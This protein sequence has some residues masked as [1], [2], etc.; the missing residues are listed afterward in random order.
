MRAAAFGDSFQIFPLT[1]RGLRRFIRGIAGRT[2][3]ASDAVSI[4]ARQDGG[5]IFKL[6]RN[7]YE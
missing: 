5:G 7:K 2:S 3:Q 4:D 6:T 1:L